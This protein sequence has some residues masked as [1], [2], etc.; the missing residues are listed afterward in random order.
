MP[1]IRVWV[2]VLRG[3]AAGG[4]ARSRA[5]LG[6]LILTAIAAS[7]VLPGPWDAT[8]A[9]AA[10]EQALPTRELVELRSAKTRTVREPDG[11]LKTTLSEQSF[12]YLDEDK[13]WKKI[14][15]SFKAS[16]S[17]GTKW[18]SGD[19]RFSVEVA[20]NAGEGFLQLHGRHGSL[21]LSLE[22]AA[23]VAGVK[24]RTNAVTFKD[25][26]ADVDLEYVVLPDG[27]KE[28]I[29]LR[30]PG[31][32]STY[33][34]RVE[35]ESG[36][37]WRHEE[38]DGEAWFFRESEAAPAFILTEPV[39]GD[40]S[41]QPSPQPDSAL[42]A[43]ES[44]AAAPGMASM[45]VKQEKDGSFRV[46]LAI[47]SDWL[48]SDER[49]Y[50]VV[51]DPSWYV[52]PDT[53]DGEYDTTNGGLPNMATGE[54]R[55]GRNGAGGAKYASVFN[56]DLATIPPGARVLDARLNAYLN[57][58]FPT[59]CGTG[60]TGDVELR[61]LTS[62]W[63][64]ST[65][66]SAVSVDAALQD[67][68]SF[69]TTPAAAWHRWSSG[70]FSQTVQSMVNGTIA[71][72]GLVLEKNAGNDA[73]GY[74]WRSARWSDPSFAPRLEVYWIADGVQVNPSTHL[75]A[76]GAELYWQHYA[77]GTSAYADAVLEDAPVGYW[78]LDE[79][80]GDTNAYDWSGKGGAATIQ[81]PTGAVRAEPGQ[82]ADLNTSTK[83][84]GSPAGYVKVPDDPVVRVNDTFTL[85]AW[86]RRSD[87]TARDMQIFN[88][89]G[90]GFGFRVNVAHKLELFANGNG[91]QIAAS[92]STILDTSWH[93][94]AA[95]KTGATVK[96]YIDGVDV[97][98]A[99]TNQTLTS[100]T[101]GFHI[102]NSDAL[103]G[104]WYG[105]ID[106]AALYP[107][108]LSATRIQAHH[109][110]ASTPLPGFQR[111]E[112]H[113]SETPNFTPSATTLI[114]TVA[115]SALQSFRDTSAKPASTFYYEVVTVTDEGTFSSNELQAELPAQA[116]GESR[117]SPAT[118][119]AGRRERTSPPAL[120]TPRRETARL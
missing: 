94:V 21:S 90:S 84:L 93:H 53:A 75:H 4:Y 79:G 50:P 16:A 49:V 51:L 63:S 60:H 108:A 24:G 28:S 41:D 81:N 99:V 83:L 82:L 25:A 77:G 18:E 17:Q 12:H 23:P 91:A 113:R 36:Q 71:N 65:P 15:P 48:A 92:T 42:D 104:P 31:A 109:A 54:I 116:S 43:P 69:S 85:E 5:Q 119:R 10:K 95:T 52:Q 9:Q 115:D 118:S 35:P 67:K 110:A 37:R 47:D 2:H 114:G 96:L 76:N 98:G 62:G 20:A 58:C 11:T 22:D 57:A 7:L 45:D 29:V 46:A 70:T 39:V 1:G 61:R 117:S 120:R 68:I 38:R 88:D 40:S 56:F 111:F 30:K 6:A 87:L 97:T 19:N 26:I 66:W 55:T 78:R 32:P 73:V 59:A 103:T 64:A 89:F 112:I 27:L 34:F 74:K 101:S 14:D 13:H 86:I 106:E 3:V 100:S 105:W 102:G 72:H 44:W 107:S 33:T 8:R 80:A